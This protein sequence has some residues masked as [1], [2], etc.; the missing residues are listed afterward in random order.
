MTISMITNQS[1]EQRSDEVNISSSSSSTGLSANVQELHDILGK[2][3]ISCKPVLMQ[4]VK[5]CDTNP[6][7]ASEKTDKLLLEKDTEPLNGKF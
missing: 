3:V 6:N 4:Q 2:Q 1:E 7:P 5:C